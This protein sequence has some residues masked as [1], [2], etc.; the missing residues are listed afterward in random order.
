MAFS[1]R[2][3]EWQN[4]RYGGHRNRLFRLQGIPFDENEEE[5]RSEHNVAASQLRDT[6]QV[7]HAIQTLIELDHQGF[8]PSSTLLANLY[9]DG[10]GVPRDDAKAVALLRKAADKKNGE[11][12]NLLGTLYV[13]GRAVPKDPRQANEWFHRASDRG[14]PAADFSLGIAYEFGVGVEKNL[15]AAGKCF[16]KAAQHGNALAQLHL[17]MF[18]ETV[19]AASKMQWRPPC[20]I[21]WRRMREFLK[22]SPPRHAS[23]LE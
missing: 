18:L 15:K 19:S 4:R 16:R 8:A 9:L 10:K 22:Q 5:L 20:G 14:I 1:R 3:K 17:G 6:K 21:G 7:D 12:E 2:H 13:T 11:A 23:S